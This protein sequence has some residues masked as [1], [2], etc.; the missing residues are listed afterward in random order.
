MT[1][2]DAHCDADALLREGAAARRL[3]GSLVTNRD[4][5]DDVAQEAMLAAWQHGPTG[6]G[7]GAWLAAVVRR[8]AARVHRGAA[9]RRRREQAA[10][11][12]ESLP[13][14]AEL[15]VRA[16]TQRAAVA[17][18]LD[19]DE[20]YRGTLLL[21]FLH[22]ASYADIARREGVTVEAVRS[23]VKRGLSLARARLDRSYRTRRA[24]L[25]PLAG[26]ARIEGGSTVGVG[27]GV[28]SMG[29]LALGAA[30]AAFARAALAVGEW[31]WTVR[32]GND[33]GA[34]KVSGRASVEVGRTTDVTVGF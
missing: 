34:A 7:R 25:V 18:V 14:T 28:M 16:Q 1:R 3:A 21:R 27:V 32:W 9:R 33:A 17:A 4:L 26:T 31:S 8:L 11:R 24:W 23:R 6:D 20:P 15:V 13:S 19:L 29:K 10:A 5:A 2:N 22:G 30:A 12:P